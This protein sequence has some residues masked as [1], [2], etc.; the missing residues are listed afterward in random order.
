[1]QELFLDLSFNLNVVNWR[2]FVEGY[3][4]ATLTVCAALR[5]YCRIQFCYLMVVIKMESQV[6]DG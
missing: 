6:A 5:V 2:P 4:G 1:M 3:M